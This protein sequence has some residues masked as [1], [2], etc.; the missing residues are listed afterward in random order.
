MPPHC[1]LCTATTEHIL[2]NNRIISRRA[3]RAAFVLALLAVSLPPAVAQEKK[4]EQAGPS[5]V[6]IETAEREVTPVYTYPGRAEAVET[7]D[8]RARVEGFLEQR[9]FREGADVKKGDLLF[10]IEQEPY[11]IVVE[12]RSAELAAAEATEKNAESDFSRKK[13]LVKRNDVSQASLDQSEAALASARADV[14]HAKAALRAAKLDLQYTEIRSPIDGR[15]SRAT[16]SV[17]NL[18][19]PSSNPLA[20]VIRYDPI[21]VTIKV[22]EEQL[23]KVRKRG[24]DINNPPVAPSLL[25][26]DGSNYPYEGKFE[27]L[28]AK[29]DEGTDTITARAEFPNT[30]KILLP[31][32][33]V[34]VLVRQKAVERAI[35]VPQA[36]VQ[37][38]ATGYFVLVV[39][40][41]NTVELRRISVD[42]QVES[43]WIVTDGLATGEKVIVQGIQKAVAGKKVNPSLQAN[44]GKGS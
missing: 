9:N 22:S 2:I 19:N 10:V 11:K 25:L 3:R 24:L 18:V 14:L 21:Y 23:I 8:L 40:R 36:A 44:S 20:T 38:D 16:Y 17:G 39:D 31:G 6:V 15:I 12:Q 35:V 42:R 4:P 7:V 33:F 5:V 43:D 34:S 41:E 28:A 29:V 26:S 27:Y 37:Q 1:L 13:S 30:D 32:Q